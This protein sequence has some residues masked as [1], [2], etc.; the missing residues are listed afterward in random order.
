MTR[1]K[2]TDD[3]LGRFAYERTNRGGRA[4]VPPDTTVERAVEAHRRRWGAEAED[5]PLVVE[6]HDMCDLGALS[7]LPGLRDLDLTSKRL[8]DLRPLAALTRLETLEI[9]APVTD[10]APLASL[11]RLDEL[12]L[13]R[14]RTT[15]L[16]P[17]AALPALTSLEL[18]DTRIDDVHQLTALPALRRLVIVHAPLTDATPLAGMALETV[19]LALTGVA[20][21]PEPAG[22]AQWT[23]LPRSPEQTPPVPRVPP[24][25]PVADLLVR[26]RRAAHCYHQR[27]ARGDL[28]AR[29]AA[30]RGLLASRDPAAIGEWLCSDRR[31]HSL[32]D[33]I[34]WDGERRPELELCGLTLRGGRGSTGFPTDNPWHLPRLA[35]PEQVVRQVWAPLADR[36]PAAVDELARRVFAVALVRHATGSRLAYLY[37]AAS[38]WDRD[39][40]WAAWSVEELMGADGIRADLCWAGPPRTTS[41]RLPVHPLGGPLPAPLRELAAVHASLAFS[42]WASRIHTGDLDLRDVRGEPAGVDTGAAHRRGQRADEDPD[43]FRGRFVEFA[44]WGW[45]DGV[46]TLDLDV[47]DAFGNPIVAWY[48]PEDD[49]D[50]GGTAPFWSWFERMVHFSMGADVTI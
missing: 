43:A 31:M 42:T 12:I 39:I 21:A 8:T 14:T 27:H 15:D 26:Y 44:G 18:T 38:R 10:L 37:G 48:G 29:A 6:C 13:R 16:R 3:G 5:Q 17:L 36:A 20:A 30:G 24:R 40:D 50:A 7:R 35:D 49:P 19:W 34:A 2:R 28:D 23:V 1:R 47:L 25:V 22:P 33:L 46:C 9:E 11:T 45:G 32:L 4:G 41:D